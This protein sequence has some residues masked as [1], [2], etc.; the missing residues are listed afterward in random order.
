MKDYSIDTDFSKKLD[1]FMAKDPTYFDFENP[2]V[3]TTIITMMHM[4]SA[5]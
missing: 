5:G 4:P 3:P 1:Y 2:K